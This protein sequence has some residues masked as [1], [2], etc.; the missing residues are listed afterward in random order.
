M[1][2]VTIAVKTEASDAFLDAL[3]DYYNGRPEAHLFGC[4]GFTVLTFDQFEGTV[5]E[6]HM[7]ALQCALV[8]YSCGLTPSDVHCVT[9]ERVEGR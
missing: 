4:D 6:A 3:S 8:L 9:I 7:K 2:E 5:T 1:W